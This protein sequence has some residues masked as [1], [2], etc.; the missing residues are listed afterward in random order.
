MAGSR[1]RTKPDLV[2]GCRFF[3]MVRSAD[4]ASSIIGA[5]PT[6]A[7]QVEAIL[8]NEA[9][10]RGRLV[11]QA[12]IP[13]LRE[14]AARFLDYIEQT[15]LDP[16]TKRYYRTG[17]RLLSNTELADM[18]LDHITT[19]DAEITKFPDAAATA[20]CAFRTLRRMLSQAKAC[21]LLQATPKIKTLPEYGRATL[22]EPE[23]EQRLLSVAKQPLYD[24]LLIIQDAGMR[25][26]EVFR[27]RWENILCNRNVIFIPFGKS[28]IGSRRFVPLSSRVRERLERR[29]SAGNRAG[30]FR[31]RDPVPAI[32]FP[33]PSSSNRLAEMLIFPSRWC[34]TALAT[35]L[36]LIFWL[37]LE[38]LLWCGMCSDTAISRPQRSISIQLQRSWR[39]LLT[40][41]TR[42]M[43]NVTFTSRFGF[44]WFGVTGLK[45]FPMSWL[46]P[47][48]SNPDMLIQSY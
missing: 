32:L 18:R 4:S 24:V 7:N 26:E 39:R 44:C 16:D 37:K 9:E 3:A 47:R 35:P 45:S 20:N 34:C 15:S 12:K 2:V 27:M 30:C 43:A 5:E 14:Y 21:D 33:W 42:K 28:R 13:L 48:D 6:K 29:R 23:I 31:R 8:I 41:E 11:A 46:P 38:I 25:P 22:I 17:W 10:R 19:A 36:Q 40:C 1:T